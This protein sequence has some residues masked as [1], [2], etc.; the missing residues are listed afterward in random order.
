FWLSMISFLGTNFMAS[1]HVI[2]GFNYWQ[3]V[4]IQS[5][6]AYTTSIIGV[7]MLGGGFIL[8]HFKPANSLITSVEGNH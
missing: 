8:K 4:E 2:S 6:G 1:A 7:S 5:L 3:L